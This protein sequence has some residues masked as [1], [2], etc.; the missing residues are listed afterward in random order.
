VRVPVKG[1]R[2]DLLHIILEELAVRYLRPGQ[3][4]RQLLALATRPFDDFSV[5]SQNLDNEWNDSNRRGCE[6]A[7]TAWVQLVSRRRG[8]SPL[9]SQEGYECVPAREVDAFPEP[10]WPTR[11]LDELIVTTFEGRNIETDDHPGLARIIG[12]KPLKV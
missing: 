5:P 4:V 8:D 12:R 10:R 11:P 9:G 1:Q 6:A 2:K 7:R 3:I